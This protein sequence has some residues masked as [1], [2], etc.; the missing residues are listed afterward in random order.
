[1]SDWA[2]ALR[3]A[4]TIAGLA[5]IT[6]LTRAFFMLPER[7]LPMPGWLREGLRYAP[8]AALMAVVAPEVVMSQGQLIDT[9]RDPRLFA[10][11]AGAGWFFWRRGILGTIVVGS[12]VMVGLRAGLGW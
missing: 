1:M 10:A 2:E 9:W 11:A 4:L 3:L 5:V 6:V 12:A 7:E 8:L